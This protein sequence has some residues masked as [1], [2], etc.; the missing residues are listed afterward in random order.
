[1]LCA[2]VFELIRVIIVCE[3]DL[4]WFR[5]IDCV[6]VYIIYVY[7]GVCRFFGRCVKEKKNL[8]ETSLPQCC[9]FSKAFTG[10]VFLFVSRH[11]WLSSHPS[12]HFLT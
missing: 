6:R 12:C 10:C 1:M 7:V 5:G 8:E 4:T 3:C 11:S 9:I 2:C